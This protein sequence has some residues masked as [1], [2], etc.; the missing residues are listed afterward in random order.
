[1]CGAEGTIDPLTGL[2]VCIEYF[3]HSVYVPTTLIVPIFLRIYKVKIQNI[4][5]TQVNSS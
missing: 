4:L 5:S 3:K 1:M 2:I